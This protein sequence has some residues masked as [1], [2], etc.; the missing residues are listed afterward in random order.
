MLHQWQRLATPDM[1]SLLDVRPGVQVKGGDSTRLD[2][3][4]VYN[5]NDCEED[6]TWPPHLPVEHAHNY[7]RYCNDAH[8]DSEASD[9]SVFES[10]VLQAQS[11]RIDRASDVGRRAVGAL[12]DGGRTACD[13]MWLQHSFRCQLG[14]CDVNLVAQR[15]STLCHV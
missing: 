15:S 11:S 1:G 9:E 5:L 13:I 4:E 2:Q 12:L 14:R 10:S 6:G 8:F 7:T 3:D